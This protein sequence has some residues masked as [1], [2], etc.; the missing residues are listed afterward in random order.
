VTNDD[1]TDR[2]D[3]NSHPAFGGIIAT[4]VL[5]NA[6]WEQLVDKGYVTVQHH[7]DTND[8][9][10]VIELTIKAPPRS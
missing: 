3:I 2:S 8:G 6:D 4:I 10:S 7:R 9:E 5:S 1:E